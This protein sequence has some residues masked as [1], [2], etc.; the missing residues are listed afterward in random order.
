MKDKLKNLLSRKFLVTLATNVMTYVI[1]LGLDSDTAKII[2]Y[3]FIAV[4]DIVYV[5]AEYGLDKASILRLTEALVETAEDIAE[6]KEVVLEDETEIPGPGDILE[7][8]YEEDLNEDSQ[9]NAEANIE[10][11]SV[12]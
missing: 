4:V 1:A 7:D 5:A 12:K 11:A 9:E 6:E 2:C 8:E 3:L 10:K